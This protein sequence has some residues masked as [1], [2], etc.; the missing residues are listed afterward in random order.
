IWMSV[1]GDLDERSRKELAKEVRDELKT[2][3]G[4]T[5]VDVVGSRDY[6]ISVEISQQDLERYGLTFSQIVDAVRGTSI[7]VAGG[8]IKTPNGDILLRANNQ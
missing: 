6:E 5:K 7:D 3:G 8:S 2:V 1:Y 4:I